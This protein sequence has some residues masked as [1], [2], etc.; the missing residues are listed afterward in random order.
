[1]FR[2]LVVP[3][4]LLLLITGNAFAHCDSVNGPVVA[5]AKAALETHDITPVLKWVA[6]E[7]EKAIRESFNRTLQVRALSPE[8]RTL[9]DNYFFETLV[10]IHREAEGEPYTG[11]KPA[12]YKVDEGIEQADAAIASGS[13]DSAAA[14]LTGEMQRGLRARFAEVIEAKKHSSDSV[15]AGRKFVHTY[16]EFIH[17]AER[18]HQSATGSAA[19]SESVQPEKVASG[20]D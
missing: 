2:R 10:R 7:K 1:M 14:A 12:S 11:I 3:A 4:V 17:Y 16:V 9:A 13:I 20:S 15:E 6:P 19:H 5:A 18:L 8:A